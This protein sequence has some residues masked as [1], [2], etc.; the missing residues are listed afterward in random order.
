MRPIH[1]FILWITAPFIWI[2]TSCPEALAIG[3]HI[4]QP[5]YQVSADSIS[6]SPEDE[7]ERA[8][9]ELIRIQDSLRIQ[10][11]AVP[12][13][14][15]PNQF[16]DSL[17]KLLVVE[18]GDFLRWIAFTNTFSTDVQPDIVKA[19]REP[20]LIFIFGLLVLFF[21]IIKLAFP[22][23]T[24]SLIQ[25]FY[26]DRMRAQINKEDTLYSSWP[27]VFLYILF[28]FSFGLFLYL[29]NA[30]HIK[31]QEVLGLQAFV[32]MAVFIM[33]LFA[34]KIFITRMLGLV[35]DVRKA[36]SEYISL[37]Y[38]S[39]FNAALIFLPAILVLSLT[40]QHIISSVL[41]TVLAVILCLFIYRFSKT[42]YSIQNK[43]RFPKFYLFIYL[44]SLEIVPVLILIKVL[45]K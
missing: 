15:R 30:Y 5:P 4:M 12:D 38:L 16:A 35:F 43:Y 36:M 41:S 1:R 27:F 6:L 32:A 13:P 19:K 31:N 8:R 22:A 2:I 9:R 14:D 17:R 45:G 28:G 26:D 23:E 25:A 39:Y 24:I 20:W 33:V 29:F 44:C 7:Q 34:I 11:I 37:L 40:P 42:L 10:F 21:G 18:N 3:H